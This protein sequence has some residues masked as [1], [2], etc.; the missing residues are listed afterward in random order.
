MAEMNEILIANLTLDTY[1]RNRIPPLIVPQGDYGARVI[2]AVITEQGKPVTVESAAAVSIVAERSGDGEALAFSGKVNTDGSVTVPVTQ[3][4]LDVPEDDVTCHVVVTGSDYQ[5]STTSFLIE[6]QKKAN[7]TEITPDDPR[8][9]VVTEVLAGE[10]ERV[11]AEG[12]RRT[13]ENARKSAEEA[14]QRAEEQR[15]TDE[16]TRVANEAERVSSE[17]SRD[18]TF[19]GWANDIA[20]LPSFDSRISANS[21]RIKNIEAGLPSSVWHVDSAAKR[22]KDV[23]ENARPKAIV[24]KIGGMT[25]KTVNL[26]HYEDNSYTQN[27]ITVTVNN[28]KSLTIRGTS[29]AYVWI[30]LASINLT[31]GEQYTAKAT[32]CPS[33]A[34]F[35]L[36]HDEDR[37]FF[38]NSAY[39]FTTTQ[40]SYDYVFAIDPNITIDVTVYPMLNEGSTA[41]PYTP[42]FEGLRSAK[43]TAVK[44]VG[45]NLIPFPYIDT[46]KTA[47]GVTFTLNAD[48][49]ITFS[50]DA[51]AGNDFALGVVPIKKGESYALSIAGSA[52]N[53]HYQIRFID[54]GGTAI[55]IATIESG[56]LNLVVTPDQIP[57]EAVAMS[58]HLKRLANGVVS[59][60][61]YP[62]CNPGTT[63]KPYTPYVEH[64]LPIP[65][66][67]QAL[68][69]WGQ[70]I[71]GTDCYNFLD[72]RPEE[73][74]TE[75]HRMTSR[76]VLS[77]DEN[78]EIYNTD[79]PY[80]FSVTLDVSAV[81]E[82]GRTME[83]CTHYPSYKNNLENTDFGFRFQNTG[84]KK[85]NRIFISDVSY[86][87]DVEAFKAYLASEY[88]NGNPVIIEYLM[89]EPE[90]T[91]ISDLLPADNLISVEGGGTLT[92]ENEHGYDM[93]NTVTYMLKEATA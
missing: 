15:L 57:T 54:A 14:R 13:N 30:D 7:P 26:L 53:I 56:K 2:R 34:Q 33:N 63:A 48:R 71:L 64:T 66:A 61:I 18:A 65:E 8:K 91:D 88:A 20:S 73:G 5:Y 12:I 75:W 6:P 60:T 55:G 93:P 24:S 21:D 86:S 68:D 78:W 42:Y 35:Y 39:T 89:Y 3:W 9:D 4:M 51:T 10:K 69:G 58:I 29:T 81:G 92:F 72:W 37:H 49:S 80:V 90:V 67:V 27:G 70:G 46:T 31:A 59:G 16:A 85:T 22:V 44:S 62:M 74:V 36:Y 17:L 79:Y 32:N 1:Q 28:D 43:V 23:P 45:R 77:G 38:R 19:K 84:V 25:Y 82:V 41:K 76:V 83:I 50:G 11:L 40:S 52:S 87:G 47:G